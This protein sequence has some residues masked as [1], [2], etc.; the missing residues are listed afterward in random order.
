MTNSI[1]P[2]GSVTVAV[3]IAEEIS[4]VGNPWE[5]LETKSLGFGMGLAIVIFVEAIVL[6]FLQISES[7]L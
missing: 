6:V 4:S 3:A 5:L 1:S 7:L 2:A